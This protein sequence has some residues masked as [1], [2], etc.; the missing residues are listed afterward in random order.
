ML[1]G[2]QLA[3][4]RNIMGF[5]SLDGAIGYSYAQHPRC[6]KGELYK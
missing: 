3:T 1:K 4:N 6:W 2:V 5:E